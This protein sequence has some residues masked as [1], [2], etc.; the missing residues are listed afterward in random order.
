M[1][2]TISRISYETNGPITFDQLSTYLRESFYKLYSRIRPQWTFQDFMQRFVK[3]LDRPDVSGIRKMHEMVKEYEENIPGPYH[4]FSLIVAVS[5]FLQAQQSKSKNNI[6]GAW[7]YLSEAQYW[8][9][10][11]QVA[12]SY[13][14]AVEKALE[15]FK[16]KKGAAGGKAR[17]SKY[18]PV[19]ERLEQLLQE[20]LEKERLKQEQLR[21]ERVQQGQAPVKRT[22]KGWPQSAKNAV[23]TIL[24]E[25]PDF[26]DFATAAHG[27]ATDRLP[28]TLAD[29]L[30]QMPSF[31]QARLAARQRSS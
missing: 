26:G 11:A 3:P 9:A 8:Y 25:N 1:T 13:G 14:E 23:K 15:E 24:E 10:I 5:Y 28:K 21:Q 20:R 12:P 19:K 30:G 27:M 31:Q 2:L 7:Y 4:N 6:E 17:A 18:E 29:W 22:G 16:K